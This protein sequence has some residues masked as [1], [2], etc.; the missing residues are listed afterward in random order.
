MINK[1][2]VCLKCLKCP[3][4]KGIIFMRIESIICDCC[5]KEIPKVKKTDIF[6]IE[7]EYYRIGK[8]SY[9]E[10]FTDI[11]CRNFGLDLCEKCAGNISL[12]LYQA[13]IELMK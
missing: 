1:L 5:R 6:G 8:L 10:P 4:S 7:R 12:E 11:N 13:R 9:G 3:M 2:Q